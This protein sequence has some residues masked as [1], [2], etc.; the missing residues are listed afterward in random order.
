MQTKKLFFKHL[1]SLVGLLLFVFLAVGSTDADPD[2]WR[3]RDDSV[4]AYIMMQ[5]FVKRH[6]ISPG[7][8]K[9]PGVLDRIDHV[10]ALGNQTYRIISYV[11]SQNAFGAMLRTRF[12]GKIKQVG[13]G[14]W[15]LISLNFP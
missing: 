7:T 2:A 12:V 14:E 4:E 8:A 15:R 3:T 13:D 11:D 5:R 1:F 9:F 6:L 10:T